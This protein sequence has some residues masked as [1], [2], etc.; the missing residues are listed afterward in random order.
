MNVKVYLNLNSKNCKSLMQTKYRRIHYI[1]N[2][3]FED[4]CLKNVWFHLS[5]FCKFRMLLLYV[6]SET[7]ER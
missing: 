5:I 4:Y 1:P 7:F 6:K 3:Y 2:H